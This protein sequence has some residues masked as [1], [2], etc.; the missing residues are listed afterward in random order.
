MA[1]GTGGTAVALRL[2]SSQRATQ[3][4]NELGRLHLQLLDQRLTAIRCKETRQRRFVRAEAGEEE[5]LALMRQ[6]RIAGHP[7]KKPPDPVGNLAANEQHRLML[8]RII[9]P[10]GKARRLGQQRVKPLQPVLLVDRILAEWRRLDQT[11]SERRYRSALPLAH[12][13]TVRWWTDSG[14]T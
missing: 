6:P 4:R 13:A 9:K 3:L 14:K 12:F 7:Q 8:Q 5:L 2:F 1:A 11:D 10:F